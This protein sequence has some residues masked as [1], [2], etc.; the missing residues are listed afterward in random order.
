MITDTFSKLATVIFKVKMNPA[1]VDKTYIP[2]FAVNFEIPA[3]VR[4]DNA[5]QSTSKCFHVIC[6]ELGVKWLANM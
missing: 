2:E 5:R 4:P 3:K 6:A 1:N